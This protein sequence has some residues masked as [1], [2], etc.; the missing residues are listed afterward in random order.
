MSPVFN[1]RGVLSARINVST[2]NLG[3][4]QQLICFLEFV[5]YSTK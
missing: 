1:G 2:N 5:V 3:Y 4:L